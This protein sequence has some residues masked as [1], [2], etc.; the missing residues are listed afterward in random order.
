[1]KWCPMVRSMKIR[2]INNWK[3]CTKFKSQQNQR[4]YS[5][6]WKIIPWVRMFQSSCLNP[7][8]LKGQFLW[9]SKQWTRNWSQSILEERWREAYFKLLQSK[10]RRNKMSQTD[11]QIWQRARDSSSSMSNRQLWILV[12]GFHLISWQA[13]QI[14]E[15]NSRLC[16]NP[17]SL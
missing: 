17:S 5:L 8:W 10:W 9:L 2:F 13:S 15:Q 3:N 14:P 6:N 1:M 4:Q 7:R 11:S 12:S 16:K